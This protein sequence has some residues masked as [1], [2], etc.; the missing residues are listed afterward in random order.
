M[1]LIVVTIRVKSGQI[2][3][4]RCYAATQL[5]LQ[6]H[7]ERT[8]VVCGNKEAWKRLTDPACIFF[9]FYIY[10]LG[11][12]P[13]PPHLSFVFVVLLLCPHAASPPREPQSWNF[14]FV[15]SSET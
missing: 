9:C 11:H 14:S 7:Q 6:V 15:Q 10:D 1:D 5:V 3:T 8:H 2:R 4:H 12:T 13:F